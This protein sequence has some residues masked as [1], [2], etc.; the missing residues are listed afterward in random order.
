MLALLAGK[1]REPGVRGFYLPA[2]SGIGADFEWLPSSA[3]GSRTGLYLVQSGAAAVAL[4][5]PFMPGAPFEPWQDSLRHTLTSR[6][7]VGVVLLRLGHYAVGVVGNEHVI[8]A[9]SGSR[10]VH[11]R[12]RAGGQSQRRWERNRDQWIEALFNQVCT[13]WRETCGG[14]VGTMDHI[15]LGG[16]RLV[17]G[18]FLGACPALGRLRSLEIARRVPVDRP[19]SDSIEHARRAIWS[20]TAF[21]GP[22]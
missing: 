9:R 17:L 6:R 12:H 16:D 21:S 10:Y 14:Y 3:R 20:A 15:A 8:A 1:W 13:A 4:A 2:G 19:G 5:P 18:R 11:G 22:A 7:I